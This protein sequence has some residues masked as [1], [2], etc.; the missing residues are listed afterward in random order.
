M[1][2]AGGIYDDTARRQH[3]QESRLNGI[4][5]LEVD[6][7]PG[8]TNQRILRVYF[9]PPGPDAPPNKVDVMLDDLDGQ[10]D[11]FDIR[12]GDRVRNIRVLSVQRIEDR[13]ELLVNQPGDFSDYRLIITYEG[14]PAPDDFP[15]DLFYRE[16][17]FN[18]K[19]GCP[20]RFDCRQPMTCPPE[21]EADIF[22]DYMAKDFD[23]F[24]QAM[25][26]LLP[27][28]IPEWTERRVADQGMMLLE[29]LA[30]TGDHLSYYQD[31]VAN[32]A[33]LET[34]RQRIS[35]RRHAQ[36]IDYS[37]HDGLSARTVMQV[38][39]R[40]GGM[41]IA[42]TPA[43][44]R[45]VRVMTQPQGIAL[46][47]NIPAD[48]ED[49]A[50]NAAGTIFE[51]RVQEP[52]EL[53]FHTRLNTLFLYNWGN[54]VAYLPV[55]ATSADLLL[56][57]SSASDWQ[58]QAGDL[59]LFEELVNPYSGETL[60]ADPNR[61]HLVRLTRVETFPDPLMSTDRI[62]D[63][64]DTA[65]YLDFL[66]ED[67]EALRTWLT[68]APGGVI[69]TRVHWK[70]EDALPFR[71][72]ISNVTDEGINLPIVNVARGN[73][74]IADQGLTEEEWYPQNPTLH[75]DWSGLRLGSRAFRF[76]LSEG[77]LAYSIPLETL[78]DQAATTLRTG[79]PHDAFPAIHTI[80]SY[81]EAA[82]D[83]RPRPW[84]VVVPTLLN[85]DRF[86]EDVVVETNNLG[87]AQLRFGTNEYGAVP[88]NNS[89][90]YVRYRVG[91]G[92]QGNVGADKLTYIV[93]HDDIGTMTSIKQVRNPLPAW[94]GTSPE[95][96][97]QVKRLAPAAMRAV[98]KRA[99]TEDD[100]GQVTEMHP[101]VERAVARFRWTGSWYTV[102]I[103]VDPRGTT[104]ISTELRR[105]LVRWV[106]RFAMAGY[107]LEIIDPIFIPLELSLAI[108]V[109]PGY[110]PTAV[111]QAVLEALSNR[112]LPDGRLG[113][114][115][116]DRFTF[117]QRLY[118]SSIYAAV[119]TVT[120]VQSVNITG[121][122]RQY[123]NAPDAETA[124]NLQR[125]SIEVGEF[126][127]IR[128]DN[129]PD[130]PEN[131]IIHLNMAGGSA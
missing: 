86:A 36:L 109:E 117:G 78:R 30:Y 29:L 129:D 4:D 62:T 91:I 128:L 72:W 49:D 34:A 44:D 21:P 58:L 96:M 116:P 81:T 68:A 126:A 16:V 89:I 102:F 107:D 10:V 131:G 111:A 124:A 106:G 127:V 3:L 100:Y 82:Y 31:A 50:L 37:M 90:F 64:L 94:G 95:S 33:Y 51:I 45:I 35:V 61:R 113:F 32:E 130:F 119:E 38:Q 101:L 24:R 52:E 125:G 7:T 43:G 105:D 19:A 46:P 9:I 40:T 20:S 83:E 60:T 12:G 80:E 23:S 63:P 118:V 59:L 97:Q 76:T 15:L 79:N 69:V 1:N 88:D 28:L 121:L 115:H 65:T 53:R 48:R 26:D 18:F 99:V 41:T 84:N 70:A 5:Y 6:A 114:F 14:R 25:I 110:F 22:V 123:A 66:R 2:F 87:Q 17:S 57:Y 39:M 108:C 85:S 56:D 73:L 120:G 11:A 27:R 93:L 98:L 47:H 55:G 75:T 54:Q 13:L 71:I 74:A 77:P 92:P 8:E 67:I 122:H 103:R 42:A 112:E 104:E